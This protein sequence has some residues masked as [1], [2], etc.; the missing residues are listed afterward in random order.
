MITPRSYQEMAINGIWDYFANGGNGNPLCCMPTGTGKSIVIAFLIYRVMSSYPGQRVLALTHVK[1]LIK[2]N[3]DKLSEVWP[4]APYG[5]FSAG[6]RKRET[7]LPIIFGGVASVAPAI[8]SL[9]RFDLVLIDEAHLMNGKIDSM[10]GSIIAKLSAINPFLKVI[11]FTATPYRTGQGLLTESALYPH[12]QENDSWKTLVAD[13]RIAFQLDKYQHWKY[14]GAQ[15]YPNNEFGKM[16]SITNYER[17][18]WFKVGLQLASQ[19][20]WGYGLIEDSFKKMAKAR[21]PEVSP[22]LSHSHSGWL[23]VVLALG[24]PGFLCILMSLIIAIKQSSGICEPW[25][26]L[27]F[28]PLMANLL[29][30]CTTEVSSTITFAVLIFWI[31][32]G[33][34][35][36]LIKLTAQQE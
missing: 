30:W 33:A 17:V 20:P 26:G 3:S 4:T 25:R 16:V 19:N 5:I 21:W 12:I 1:E 36:T 34:G 35:L 31:S 14:A 15:G 10:Y 9:G 27:V 11:G 32:W 22:N 7:N 23:D 18:A 6:L 2:Q 24:F 29:L 28:W 13:T 8:D